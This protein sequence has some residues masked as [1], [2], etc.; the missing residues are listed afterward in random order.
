[1]RR[2]SVT[3]L[4][5]LTNIELVQVTMNQVTTNVIK[6]AILN[7]CAGCVLESHISSTKVGAE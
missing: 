6:R 2:T 3:D 5:D 4:N 1:M 7:T